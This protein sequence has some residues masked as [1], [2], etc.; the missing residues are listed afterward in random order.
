VGGEADANEVSFRFAD[1]GAEIR[2][3]YNET[4][5][6]YDRHQGGAPHVTED[7]VQLSFRNVVVQM[8]EV[9]EGAIVDQAGNRT[10]DIE[11]VG[12]GAALV[13]RA[14]RAFRGTWARGVAGE[15]TT[16][17]DEAGDPIPL[18]PGSTIV[19]LVPSGRDIFVQ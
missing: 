12:E 8:V 10:R 5:G 6:R 1:R 18:A 11:L 14:G 7:D 2:Y 16:L 3:T 17:L 19:E 9:R 4:T 15:A 13:V